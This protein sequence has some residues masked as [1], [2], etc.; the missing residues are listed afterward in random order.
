MAVGSLVVAFL[1]AGCSEEPGALGG[2]QDPEGSLGPVV[3]ADDLQTRNNVSI[4]AERDDLAERDAL[5]LSGQVSLRSV[6]ARATEGGTPEH[7]EA[8][9]LA[10][11]IYLGDDENGR[12]GPEQV[13]TLVAA[14][15]EDVAQYVYS[16]MGIPERLGMEPS[17]I[18]T[19]E[20]PWLRTEV[21]EDGLIRTT[22]ALYVLYPGVYGE[23]DGTWAYFTTQSRHRDGA[24][25]LTY[26]H[27]LAGPTERVLSEEE[28]ALL[29]GSV[30]D[31][32]RPSF[33]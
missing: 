10:A 25:Q 15:H 18:D 27:N 9:A 23:A 5:V 7:G 22:L 4:F 13:A 29:P 26:W 33:R 8:F 21:L 31:W 6:L 14:E 12:V 16:Q 28:R 11:S 32:R 19:A 17:R 30:S 20:R 3:D 24:W 2:P 1:L